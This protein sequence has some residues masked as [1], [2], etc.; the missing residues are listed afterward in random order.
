MHFSVIMCE[1]VK[2]FD[3]TINVISICFISYYCRLAN[4]FD[5]LNFQLTVGMSSFAIFCSAVNIYAAKL[6]YFYR[7]STHAILS[8][9]LSVLCRCFV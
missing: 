4:Q 2:A 3:C 5:E 6:Y 9:S 1:S 7:A 8:I